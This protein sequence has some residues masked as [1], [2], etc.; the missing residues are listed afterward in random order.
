MSLP[1]SKTINLCVQ[2]IEPICDP[3]HE[4]PFCFFE[5]SKSLLLAAHGKLSVNTVEQRGGWVRELKNTL[6]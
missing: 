5:N 2:L 6:N 3:S 1:T 4:S